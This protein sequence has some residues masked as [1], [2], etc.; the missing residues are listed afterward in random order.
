MQTRDKSPK[1]ALP[2][3]GMPQYAARLIRAAIDRL[4]EDCIVVSSKPGVPVNGMEEALGQP[5][6]WVDATRSVSWDNLG[7]DVPSIF[8]QSGWSFPAFLA[9]GREVKA[10]GEQVIGLSD[11]NW[12]GDFRQ[13]AL[14]PPAF[15]A[16]HRRHF[17]AMIVAGRQGER[18]KGGG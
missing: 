4:G 13:L 10:I 9:L 7:L 5:V 18:M 11:A 1:I 2:W 12:R 8:V 17:D 14:G 16:R 6:H 3:N 15:C